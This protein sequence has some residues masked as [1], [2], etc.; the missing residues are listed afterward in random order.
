MIT[1]TL[2]HH[3]VTH[4]QKIMNEGAQ[5]TT[6]R[7]RLDNQRGLIRSSP[8]KIT[9]I[10]FLIIGAYLNEHSNEAARAADQRSKSDAQH[11]QSPEVLASGVQLELVAEHPDLATPTGI[12]V[13]Q[14]GTIWVASNHTHF[15]PEGYQGPEKDEIICFKPDGSRSVFYSASENTM[16]LERGPANDLYLA[17]RD[18]ILRLLDHDQNLQ[19]DESQLIVKLETAANYPHNGLSGLTWSP[20]G[21]LV[22]SIGE[23][24][25]EQ[26]KLVGSD[27]TTLTGS[28]EG[29]IFSC[30]PDGTSLRRIAR[31]FWNPFGLCYRDGELFAAENDPGSRPPCRLLHVVE[32]GDYGYQRKYGNESN[33]P[34]VCWNGELRGTLPMLHALGEA[35]CGIIPLHNGLVV[36][37]W[38]EHRVDY[39]PLKKSGDTYSTHRTTLVRGGRE[40]RPTCIARTS[41]NEL[42]FTDWV[43]GSYEIHGK[44]RIWRLAINPKE[45]SDWVGETSAIHSTEQATNTPTRDTNVPTEELLQIASRT[46]E[47]FAHH[48]LTRMLAQRVRKQTMSNN[49]DFPSVES[50]NEAECL[51]LLLAWKMAHPNDSKK[52]AEFLKHPSSAIQFE[53]I[54]WIADQELDELLPQVNG[55]LTRKDL[56]F[57]TLEATLAALNTLQGKP[58]EGISNQANLVKLIDSDQF[59]ENLKANLLPLVTADN[60]QF[61]PKKW[62]QL[63]QSKN[64]KLIRELVRTVAISTVPEANDFLF[65][66]INNKEVSSAIRADAIAGFRAT[67]D[68]QKNVLTELTSSPDQPIREEAI[69]AM[70]FIELAAADRQALSNVSVAFPESKDLVESIL[71]PTSMKDQRPSKTNIDDWRKLLDSVKA[72]VNLDAGRRL[73]FHS[74]TTNC[75]KCHRH[76]GRGNQLGPDLSRTAVAN[77]D[78][79]LQSLLQPSQR[80]DPQ[81][82]ARN[83]LLDDGTTFTGILLRDGGGGREVYRNTEGK[84]QVLKTEEIVRRKESTTSL[85]PE[86][87][88]DPLSNREIRDLIAFI[89]SPQKPTSDNKP[90]NQIPVSQSPQDQRSQSSWYGDWWF[91]FSDGYGGWLRYR[92]ETPNTAQLLWRVGSP[93]EMI[94]EITQSNQLKLT[95]RNKNGETTYLAEQESGLIQIH[96]MKQVSTKAVGKRCPTMPPKPDLGKVQFG[97]AIDLFNGKDLSGWKLQPS[98][99]KNGWRAENGIL[100]NTTPKTDFGAYGDHGNLRTI[101][102]FGD[103]QVH[104]EFKVE[105]DCNSGIYIN[106]LYEAQVVDRDS[107]MQGINGPGAIFGRICPEFNAGLTGGQWQTYD[108]TLVDRHISVRLNGKLIIDNQPVEGCTGGALFGDVQR[109]GP[110]Y[111]QGD[112][113]SVSYRN[114]WIRPRKSPRL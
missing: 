31:G 108:I 9:L 66:I 85:M 25:A 4:L 96:E 3:S 22:F 15:R 38:T 110:L 21:Q 12:D 111:L 73:F 62:Q 105:S 20:E 6:M 39:Y 41:E 88:L 84:E 37:S 28:G 33:H 104:V 51:E 40:F 48:N 64:E 68:A 109:D 53:A 82:H 101:A 77:R 91:D 24:F 13:D 30:A 16:D 63:Q 55:Q 5:S 43:E 52:V 102:E 92:E 11:Q 81:F 90:R 107:K 76:Y 86:N 79:I 35:P 58:S 98:S 34:F 60:Q 56:N 19:C 72:P 95:R 112:H 114:L 42:F 8:Q 106:G 50:L 99:A 97:E 74:M 49:S 87:L 78:E 44:G 36:T 69:R 14:D 94:A 45:I 93:R 18:R 17:Q 10:A 80:I 23:N 75:S 83:L 65:Q 32:E 103:C 7:T 89:S 46:S 100:V 71:A 70:R 59:S 113:T 26:W 29:G 2:L 27:N 47:P 1:A 61:G 57:Q 67:N 54:R